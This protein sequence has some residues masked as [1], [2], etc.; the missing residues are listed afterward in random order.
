MV[1]V[2]AYVATAV[3]AGVPFSAG[4]MYTVGRTASAKDKKP[5]A[6]A[7]GLQEER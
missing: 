4:R 5:V 6:M 3:A 2:L 7:T 1:D